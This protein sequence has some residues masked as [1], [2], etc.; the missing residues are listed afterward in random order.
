VL[1]RRGPAQAA[2]TTPELRELGELE[3]ADVIVD[4]A[5]LR[6]DEHSERWLNSDQADA[7][8]R[9]N[10]ELMRAFAANIPTRSHR[11]HLRFLSSPTKIL[12]DS[13]GRV[14]GIR[15]AIN[16][17]EP[18]AA[19]ALR[20]VPAGHE[21]FLP[22][23]LVIS[24]VGY[25]ASPLAGFPLDEQRGLIRNEHGRVLDTSGSRCPGE[26]VAGWVKRGPSGVI[27]TNKKCAVETVKAIQD[28]RD[29]GRLPAGER[30]PAPATEAWL[31]ERAPVVTW[32]GW[33][34]I[35]EHETV[36]GQPHGRPRVKLIDRDQMTAIATTSADA[37]VLRA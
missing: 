18:D 29:C 22:C 20:A 27:G 32:S 17:I 8:S 5:D 11:I 15:I 26:Y 25:R 23:G 13:R 16:Q 7:T 3:R 2:F 37:V 4:P 9:R 6:L 35:D 1:G 10:V 30:P 14:S 19:G 24:S 33:R 12:A 28:D 36:A 34:A 31:K 21:L